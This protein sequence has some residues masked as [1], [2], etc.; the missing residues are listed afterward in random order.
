MSGTILPAARFLNIFAA[1]VQS[2][3]RTWDHGP[4]LHCVGQGYRLQGLRASGRSS[5]QCLLWMER[6]VL[7][8]AGWTQLTER[9]CIPV[10]P[11]G[12][13]QFCHSPVTQLKETRRN[14]DT[15]D[16]LFLNCCWR[17]IP[18][19]LHRWGAG[20]LVAV[21][22]VSCWF[23]IRLVTEAFM[24]HFAV[25]FSSAAI[26]LVLLSSPTGLGA[27]G[28]SLRCPLICTVLY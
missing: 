17:H 5:L 3:Q 20:L 8:S 9:I 4:T 14:Q 10:F 23:Q 26:S 2:I 11:Q 25:Y 1:E 27:V 22:N 19:D 6:V 28:P 13:L 16:T 18:Q 21:S 12:L 24:N 7:S 15:F